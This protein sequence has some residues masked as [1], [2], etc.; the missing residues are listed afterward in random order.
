MSRSS[1]EDDQEEELSFISPRQSGAELGEVGV[2]PT[3]A[4]SGPS[5]KKPAKKRVVKKL[6]K[7][8]G[9]DIGS[10]RVRR[11]RSSSMSVDISESPTPPPVSVVASTAKPASDPTLPPV[12]A[13]AVSPAGANSS[14]PQLKGSQLKGSQVLTKEH[15]CPH[16]GRPQ[17]S[18]DE[19][20]R[21]ILTHSDAPFPG[22]KM[23]HRGSVL[24]K[25]SE[26]EETASMPCDIRLPPLSEYLSSRYWW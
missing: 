10:P 17:S 1:T 23:R 13:A 9:S 15:E 7:K 25:K 18:K 2:S 19:L 26:S 14:S 12:A 4:S 11:S 22:I 16:C 20:A 21:H 3:S 24:V 8:N 5:P 6:R